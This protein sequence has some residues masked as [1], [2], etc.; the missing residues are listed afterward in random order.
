MRDWCDV[1]AV[2]RKVRGRICRENGKKGGESMLVGVEQRAV[3][4]VSKELVQCILLYI[5]FSRSPSQFL[6]GIFTLPSFIFFPRLLLLTL[7][8][9]FPHPPGSTTPVFIF[10]F[11][12]LSTRTCLPL[13]LL[14]KR[15]RGF[16][17]VCEQELPQSR[18]FS[19]SPCPKAEVVWRQ[20]R[21]FFS[22]I[23]PRILL[24]LPHATPASCIKCPFVQAFALPDPCE[25]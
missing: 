19:R 11:F 17:W 8:L 21:V 24:T 20:G 13:R 4:V 25:E 22:W 1:Q 18:H 15:H 7:L 9:L 3:W 23:P 16:Y 10:M 6:V 14:W 12:C 5:F 2:R